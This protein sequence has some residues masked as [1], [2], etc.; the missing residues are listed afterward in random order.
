MLSALTRTGHTC[1]SLH[2][3]LFLGCKTRVHHCYHHKHHL[4]KRLVCCYKHQKHL[5]QTL[6]SYPPTKNNNQKHPDC[7]TASP[8]ALLSRSIRDSRSIRNLAHNTS[9]VD[10]ALGEIRKSRNKRIE[11]ISSRPVV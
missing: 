4:Q 11:Q 2:L 7:R 10:L 8:P 1:L 5:P 6:V 3:A 9:T